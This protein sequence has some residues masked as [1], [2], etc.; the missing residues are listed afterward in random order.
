LV[1]LHLGCLGRGVYLLT[2]IDMPFI[3]DGFRDG[4]AI[5]QWIHERFLEELERR[6]KSYVILEGNKPQTCCMLESS[7]SELP[8]VSWRL[9]ALE[10]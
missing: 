1:K 9:M 7:R 2:G 6:G 8:W 4:E 5:R 3:Q 10:F